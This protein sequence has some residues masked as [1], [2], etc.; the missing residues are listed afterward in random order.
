[1]EDWLALRTKSYCN[2]R[3]LQRRVLAQLLVLL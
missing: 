3:N 1:V 2:E